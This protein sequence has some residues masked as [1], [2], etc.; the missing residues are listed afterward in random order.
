MGEGAFRPNPT[1]F[2]SPEHREYS[3]FVQRIF[4]D[5]ENKKL[6]AIV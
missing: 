6:L 3:H 1:T 4:I 2:V 5:F